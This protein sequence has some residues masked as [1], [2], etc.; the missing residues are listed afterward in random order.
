MIEEKSPSSI[1]TRFS[2]SLI[3]TILRG[4]ITLFT[5]AL[6]ARWL[7]PED[8]GRMAFLL[9]IF[10]SF[11]QLID[12][13]SSSAFFTF[14][15]QR[16]RS[17]DFVTYYW[18]WIGLQFFIA[19]IVVSLL[20]PDDLT[21]LIWMG[22]SK[23]LIV[24][25]LTAVFMQSH[26]WLNVMQMAESQRKT[27]EV[28]KISTFIVALHLAVLTILW[29]FDQ[30]ILPLIFI[31]LVIEWAVAS[32]LALKLYHTHD[33][34]IKKPVDSHDTILSVIKEFS[35]YC[36]P[37]IP[38]VWLSFAHT[39]ADRW[40]LQ[41]WGGVKEQAYFSVALQFSALA[42]LA[43]TSILKIF[44]KE[45]AEAYHRKEFK[46]MESLYHRTSKRL[47][48]LGAFLCAGALPWSNE[49]VLLIFGE[50]YLDGTL[51]FLL[52][53]LYTVHQSMG[54]IGST[55]L[56]A[57]E[58]STVQ[59]KIGLWFMA[60]SLVFVYF[61]LAPKDMFIPGLEMGSEGLALK[62]VIMQLIQVNI[63]AWFVAKIFNWKFEWLYQFIVLG[64]LIALGVSIKVLVINVL[65]INVI[66]S[67]LIA[68]FFYII[69]VMLAIYMMPWIVDMDKELINNKITGYKLN[70][71]GNKK[72]GK[73]E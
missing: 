54:Q 72:K 42:L 30:L 6:I 64:L 48:F 66:A 24:L 33:D 14:L 73:N 46:K 51:V 9:A 13:S 36:I 3:L 1:A 43:T 37:F 5:G 57:T 23:F 39:I 49:I 44:W 21:S 31:A 29:S 18:Y 16:H 55:M 27:T 34:C 45:I 11:R 4:G 12:M 40:L 35:I 58:K 52:I 28:Q 8:Y 68:S 47:Y 38:Y 17:R 65:V 63:A 67:I 56:Y 19:F 69:I 61:I 62:M 2:E 25:A 7:G 20:I 22:E 32:L 59:V 10:L 15:S 50:E 70:L 53:L 71:I 26:V 60:F 41:Y